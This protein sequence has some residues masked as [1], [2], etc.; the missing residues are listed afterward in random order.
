MSTN[1]HPQLA[2][3]TELT[4]LLGVSRTRVGQLASLGTLPPAYQQL[5]MGR[6]WYVNDI[7]DWAESRGR[8]IHL[9]ALTFLPTDQ[10]GQ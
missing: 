1:D 6:I 5:H 10:E 2:G 4:W 9:D 3:V 8:T 7:I